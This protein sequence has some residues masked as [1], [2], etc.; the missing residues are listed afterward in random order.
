MP[1]GW[2]P[3]E[4]KTPIPLNEETIWRHDVMKGII[5]RKVTET[6]LITT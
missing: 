4:E 5:H 2:K 1:Q 3:T 6:W